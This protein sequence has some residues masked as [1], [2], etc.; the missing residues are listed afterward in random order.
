LT[1]SLRLGRQELYAEAVK[2]ASWFLD[3][4]RET[5]V[6]LTKPDSPLG[7]YDFS[8]FKGIS[9]AG[10]VLLRLAHPSLQSV[11]AFE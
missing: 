4:E 7:V 10:Y 6:L 8:L 9:G 3:R 11:L 2:R 1:A 5:G